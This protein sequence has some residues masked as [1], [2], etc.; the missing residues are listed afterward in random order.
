MT[1]IEVF[2]LADLSRSFATRTRGKEVARLVAE[3]AAENKPEAIVVAW[4]GVTAASPSFVDE[5]VNGIQRAI[6]TESCCSRISFT[7]DEPG[8]IN[9][10]DAILRRRDSSIRFAVRH[11]K[12]ESV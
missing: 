8:I 5:F 12:V 11:D 1:G 4:N 2:N 7:G 9:L 3:L 10:V 6:H